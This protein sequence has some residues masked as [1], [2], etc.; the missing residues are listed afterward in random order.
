MIKILPHYCN[1]DKCLL[2]SILSNNMLR[3]GCLQCIKSILCLLL[4]I[5]LYGFCLQQ[6]ASLQVSTLYVHYFLVPEFF[7]T[8]PDASCEDASCHWFGKSGLQF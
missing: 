4:Q 5:V 1:N 7:W 2:Y 8:N 6:L 3:K